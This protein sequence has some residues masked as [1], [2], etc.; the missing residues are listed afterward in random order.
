MNKHDEIAKIFT[1]T[2]LG[3]NYDLDTVYWVSVSSP[4]GWLHR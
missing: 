4:T 2:N 1:Y 3:S